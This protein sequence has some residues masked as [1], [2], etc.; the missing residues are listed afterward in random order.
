MKRRDDELVNIER[1][2]F[3]SK[4]TGRYY[5]NMKESDGRKHRRPH[6][7]LKAARKF[8]D[9]MIME[10]TSSGN[11]HSSPTSRRLTI[12]E[13]A[14][15]FLEM[16]TRTKPKSVTAYRQRLSK[17]LRFTEERRIQYVDQFTPFHADDLLGYLMSPAAVSST[18]VLK[19]RGL[20]NLTVNFHITTIREAFKFAVQLHVIDRNPMDVV[21]MLDIAKAKPKAFSDAEIDAFF[22]VPIPLAYRRVFLAL[23]Y[24]GLRISELCALRWNHIDFRNPAKPLLYVPGT[25]TEDS[26]R[27]IGL[28]T[29]MIDLLREII[30]NPL[31]DEY[32]FCNT[33]GG[34]LKRGP[35]L[36]ACKRVGKTAG[37]TGSIHTH[38]FRHT[39]AGKLLSKGY[40]LIR[41]MRILGQTSPATTE[42]YCR[43]ILLGLHD[44]ETAERIMN[45]IVE[46]ET[47]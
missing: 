29:E 42:R 35:V 17:L 14:D 3:R 6:T 9:E 39:L 5:T 41:I 40:P 24:S 20:A 7:S 43:R 22:A 44:V 47:Y 33:E 26:E 37:M 18:K 32:P 45:S 13:L 27:T 12:E 30:A 4:R 1:A 46:G 25:K 34:E 8:R 11:H 23:M 10:R 36:K 16:K 15:R 31:S 38:R 28:E 19:G 21:P 2:I